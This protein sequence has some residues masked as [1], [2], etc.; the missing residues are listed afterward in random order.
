MAKSEATLLLKIKQTGQQA[1]SSTKQA[2]SNLASLAKIA[3]AAFVTMGVAV[4]GA[5]VQAGKFEGVERSFR[6]LAASQGQQA[7]KMLAKMKELSQGTVSDLKL[8]QQANQALLLGLPVDRFGDMLRIAQSASVATGESMDFMLNSIV[9]GL[10][11]GSKLMLDNLGIVFKAEDAYKEYAAQLG[12]TAD[13]LTEAEKKQAFI[14]KALQVGVDNAD[15]AGKGSL[16]F[17]QNL[18]VLKAKFENLTIQVG[19]AAT[20]AFQ[21]FLN[22]VIS[23]MSDLEE[24]TKGPGALD[25]FFLR[26][27]QSIVLLKG[28]FNGLIQIMST[29]LGAIGEAIGALLAGEFVE[30]G[31]IMKNGI[32]EQFDG[33][34]FNYEKTKMEMEQLD[35]D[36]NQ[37]AIE[38]E[39]AKQEGVR[40]VKQEF[41]ELEKE[42]D[43]KEWE[44]KQLLEFERAQSELDLIGATAEKKLDIKQRLLDKELKAAETKEKKEQILKQKYATLEQQLQA[45]RDAEEE[46]RKQLQLQGFSTFYGGLA[47][48]QESSSK[49]LSAIGRAA[50]IAKATIDAYVAINTTLA[51]LPFP[52][53]VAAAAGIGVQAFVNVSK[54][55]GVKFAEGGIVPAS[56]GGTS[57]I[58]G[59]GGRS[60]A[61]IP[62]PD[63]FNPDDGLGFGGSVVVNFNGPVMG[64]PEQARELAIM[65]DE[66]LFKLRQNNESKSFDE[67]FV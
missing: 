53:N 23:G 65:L 1:L 22:Q 30:A 8:M 26:T 32:T 33:I 2:L 41:K 40:A 58:I 45:K 55:A 18:D 42:E 13:K 20:P 54:I 56:S 25:T 62:L 11:R 12:K 27:A 4:A 50:A 57:A 43:L 21:F 31:K 17:A 16:T 47:S 6:A 49:E 59:E 46:K 52:A 61:V 63:N 64:S 10:G 37:R 66:E 9:T 44:E 3:G 36:Y 67:A 28:V 15:K 24:A 48:L 34:L 39:R 7:D 51:S 19:Q 35:F 38:A 60:E 29:S 14:N 5:V